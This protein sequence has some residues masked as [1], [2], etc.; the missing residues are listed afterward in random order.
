M[1]EIKN[2]I[3]KI[4]KEIESDLWNNSTFPT[5]AEQKETSLSYDDLMKTVRE[6]EERFPINERPLGIIISRISPKTGFLRKQTDEGVWFFVKK[7]YWSQVASEFVRKTDYPE[8]LLGS[9]QPSIYSV[10][11]YEDEEI[12]MDV[13]IYGRIRTKEERLE[14]RF[15]S[16]ENMIILNRRYINGE[17]YYNTAE[18]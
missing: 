10:P 16:I 15:K 18:S 14:Q 5:S 8:N 11:V 17:G 2:I 12:A 4:T 1:N 6:I 9:L 3:K 13:W 7:E